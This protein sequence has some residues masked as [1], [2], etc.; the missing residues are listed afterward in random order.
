MAALPAPDWPLTDSF[1]GLRRFTLEDVP[2][3]TKACQDLEIPRWT[4]GIPQPYEEGHAREWIARH[5]GYWADGHRAPFAFY[6]ESTAELSG[7]MSLVDID[8]D[9]RRAGV[10]YWAAPWA[11]N[12]G[13]TTR[14]LNLACRWGFDSLK[15]ENVH[16][17]TLLGNVASE[18]VAEKAG[19]RLVGTIDDHRPSGALNSEARYRVRHWVRR[20]E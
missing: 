9:E 12:R 10:G 4:A 16:L 6:M 19:F 8:L 20:Y 3:V 15:L 11:R 14:A 2:A 1:V 17:M 7:S 18:R 13:A 5:D